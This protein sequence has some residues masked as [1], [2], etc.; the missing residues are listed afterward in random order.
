MLGLEDF[1]VSLAFALTV[2]SVIL[3]VGY[4]IVKWNKEGEPGKK[5]IAEE[6]RWGK[7]EKKMANRL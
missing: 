5:E 1:W 2:G 7:E 6:K 4:G 3:C